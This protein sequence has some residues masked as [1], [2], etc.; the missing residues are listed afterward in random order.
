METSGTVKY[1]IFLKKKYVSVLQM[2]IRPP[3]I[4]FVPS[5]YNIGPNYFICFFMFTTDFSLHGCFY[6]ST[7]SSRTTNYYFNSI[8][9]QDLHSTT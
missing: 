2:L 9:N 6:T 5:S 7:I 1:F 4:T 3:C 8:R